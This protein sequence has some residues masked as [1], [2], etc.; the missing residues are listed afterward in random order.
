MVKLT[1]F[2]VLD[3]FDLLL[4]I[5]GAEEVKVKHKV[6][7]IFKFEAVQETKK[8]ASPLGSSFLICLFGIIYNLVSYA[9]AIVVQM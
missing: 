7:V 8:A 9:R 4:L 5:L 6:K 3:Q 2:V 1:I